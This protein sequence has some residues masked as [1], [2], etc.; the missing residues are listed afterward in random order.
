MPV[1]HSLEAVDEGRCGLGGFA[2]VCVDDESGL[3]LARGAL[4]GIKSSSCQPPDLTERVDSG[5]AC[6][7]RRGEVVVDL[8]AFLGVG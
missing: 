8:T 4:P 3:F 7:G 6:G 2:G 1:C 5:A